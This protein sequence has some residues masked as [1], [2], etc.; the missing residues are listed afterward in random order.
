MTGGARRSRAVKTSRF[1][2]FKNRDR[3]NGV[4]ERVC[5]CAGGCHAIGHRTRPGLHHRVLGVRKT[6]G[7][8]HLWFCNET[9][10]K[11]A[12]MDENVRS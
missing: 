2:R 7:V 4:S 6:G 1:T 10:P 12:A 8:V 3:I 11:Q 9:F 5:E